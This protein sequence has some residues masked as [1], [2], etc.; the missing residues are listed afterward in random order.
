MSIFNI[1]LFF[2]VIMANLDSS[3]AAQNI[4]SLDCSKFSSIN[5]KTTLEADDVERFAEWAERNSN[6]L[7]TFESRKL[8][9]E[10]LQQYYCTGR[11]DFYKI[12]RD[13]SWQGLTLSVTTG[14]TALGSK[15]LAPR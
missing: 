3:V 5:F 11:R 4:A 8:E 2:V 12:A 7:N 14:L 13:L 1:L 6:D 10:R 9:F 15:F